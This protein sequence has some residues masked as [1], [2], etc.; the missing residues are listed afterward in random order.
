MIPVKV[1]TEI[2]GPKS[3][4]L[5]E[6]AFQSIAPTQYAGLFGVAIESGKGIYL[7]DVDGNVFL[8][9]LAG[10]SAVSVG[11]GREEIIDAYAQTA[12]KIQHSCFPYSPNEEAIRLADKL[13][14]ITPGDF[15]KRVMFGMSGSDGVDAAIKTA[16]KSTNKPRILS[17]RGGYHGSTGFSISANGFEGLQRGLFISPDF[18]MLDFPRTPQQAEKTLEEVETLLKAGDVAALVTEC[19]QG[20]GGNV[21]PP[22]VFHSTLNDLVHQHDAIFV[23]DEVQSGMGRTGK[24]WE[25][26]HFDIVPDILCTAKALTSGYIPMGACIARADLALTLAKAQHLF[27]YSGHPPSAAVGSKVIEIIERENLLQNAAERGAQLT[28]G[29][30]K[31]VDTYPFAKEVRGRGLHIGFE[32]YDERTQTPLG[33]LFAFRCAEKGIYPGYFGANN[34][35]MRLHPPLIITEEEMQY[36][37]DVITS[38]VKEWSNGTFPQSTIDNYRKFGVGLGTD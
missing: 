34:E 32:V 31:L 30:Q 25:S 2:P 21:V 37:I 18:V 35:V 22:V 12:L 6:R 3:Q 36:A 13:I 17:F 19:I 7:T 24:W 26:E 8:D 15:E 27:T 1:N 9:F 29:L 20:D 10:A 11:Y 28:A 23:V 33:G 4:E 5:V 14:E 38:V 16:R